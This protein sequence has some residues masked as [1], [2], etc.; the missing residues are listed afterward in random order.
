MIGQDND[1]YHD[2]TVA[3]RTLCRE[4]PGEYHRK[5][6]GER[7]TPEKIVDAPTRTGWMASMPEECRF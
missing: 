5:I 3:V 4:F 2:I 1:E 7:I 6:D